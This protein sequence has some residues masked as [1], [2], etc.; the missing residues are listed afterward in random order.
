[1][2]AH[3]SPENLLAF[4]FL[5][6]I[7]AFHQHAASRL[8]QEQSCVCARHWNYFT[9]AELHIYLQSDSDIAFLRSPSKPFPW[10]SPCDE[11]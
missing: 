2:V 5:L 9:H 11:T 6:L 4:E 3:G 10:L 7:S 8:Y 1:M